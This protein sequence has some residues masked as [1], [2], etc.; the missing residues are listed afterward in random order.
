MSPR[1]RGVAA[2]VRRDHREHVHERR[3]LRNDVPAAASSGV[4]CPGS[5]MTRNSAAYGRCRRPSR[6]LGVLPKHVRPV[7]RQTGIEERTRPLV[8][9]APEGGQG[10]SSVSRATVADAA[11]RSQWGRAPPRVALPAMIGGRELRDDLE[12]ARRR[13]DSAAR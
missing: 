4:A 1:R 2:H 3:R 5:P 7:E 6:S 10:L 8:V 12:R 11:S 9:A 13:A